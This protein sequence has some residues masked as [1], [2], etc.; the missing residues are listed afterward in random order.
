M[1]LTPYY[2]NLD[3]I[4]YRAKNEISFLSRIVRP[5]WE[6]ID[7]FLGKN[8]EI[9]KLIKNLQSSEEK[10]KNILLKEENEDKKNEKDDEK[11]DSTSKTSAKKLSV[12]HSEKNI[13]QHQ[14]KKKEKIMEKSI[15][16]SLGS[17]V[18]DINSDHK[19][20]L[21]ENEKN[22]NSEAFCKENDNFNEIYKKIENNDDSL[23]GKYKQNNEIKFNDDN[24]FNN[25]NFK[26][27]DSNNDEEINDNDNTEIKIDQE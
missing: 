11:I 13:T 19:D 21:E 24:E 4:K 7:L 27:E 26:N 25:E 1:P 17:S 18:N 6:V 5:I 3:I 22:N 2:K 8:T 20:S 23:E 14:I 12:F 9:K 10:W 15:K 16:E